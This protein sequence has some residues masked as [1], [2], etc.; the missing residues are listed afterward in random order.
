MKKVLFFLMLIPQIGFLQNKKT[1]IATV[2]RLKS[3]S[4][5]L[6]DKLKIK[7]E[8]INTKNILNENLKTNLKT[9][10]QDFLE[11]VKEY[12]ISKNKNI[13]LQKKIE[14]LK[15]SNNLI[16]DTISLLIKENESLK[17]ESKFKVNYDKKFI[18]SS[19]KN[20]YPV[21]EYCDSIFLIDFKINDKVIF[22][23]EVCGSDFFAGERNQSNRIKRFS[24]D[25]GEVGLHTTYYFLNLFNDCITVCK[26]LDTSLEVPFFFWIKHYKLDLK[27]Y[28]WELIK[29]IEDENKIN[30]FMSLLYPY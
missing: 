8:E 24:G 9:V 29:T 3:D 26:E 30:N 15:L 18:N 13:N 7:S 11:L 21:S 4:T 6:H 27:S 1:L 14:Y 16:N 28:S 10:N 12:N 19:N 2:N 25:D 20:E 22:S 17:L 23:E 5:I